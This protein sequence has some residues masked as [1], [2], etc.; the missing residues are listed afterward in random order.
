MPPFRNLHLAALISA[1]MLS[2]GWA[3]SPGGTLRLEI[4]TPK[5][6]ITGSSQ[7]GEV[8]RLDWIASQLE[9]QRADG[10]WLQTADWFAFFS[11]AAGRTA[12]EA[13]GVPAADYRAIRFVV[14][15]DKA[16]N[17]RTPDTFGSDHSLRPAIDTMHWGWMGGFIFLA[18]EGT[19]PQGAFSYHL[20]ND[21]KATT[22]TLPVSFKGGGPVT[23]SIALDVQRLLSGIDFASDPRSSHSREGDPVVEKLRKAMP[24]AFRVIDVSNELFQTLSPLMVSAAPAGTHPVMLR[25]PQRFPQLRLPADNPLTEEGIA[26]GARLFADTRLSI[27]NTQSCASC[28]ERGRAFADA[29]QFS[30][31]AE[32]Q[33]GKRNAMALFN[34]AWHDGFFW[35]GRARTL[36]EQVLMPV[37]DKHEMNETL[38]RVVAKLK[39]D[40]SY[41]AAF[42]SAFGSPEVTPDRLAMALEQHLLSITS[43]DSKFDHAVRKVEALSDAEARGLK[44]FVT[45][46]DPARGLRGADCFHCHGGMLF[47]NHA[48]HNNGLTLAPD[49]IGREAVT[50]NSADRGKFKTPSL[51]NIALTA[52]Y[53]HDGRFKTLE[54]V[55]EHYDH[56]LARSPTLDPN[57]AKHPNEGLR[58]TDEEKADLVAFLKTLTD[59]SLAQP[60]TTLSQNLPSKPSN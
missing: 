34:L 28:H 24:K 10:S 6:P 51:R 8:S 44:L 43:Q 33:V 46:F 4:V 16:T 14:G 22:L 39:D 31:G 21:G 25:V 18:V 42:R 13:T 12:A 53:M 32:G 29:R 26:L 7:G 3:A 47:T 11:V 54:E 23:V 57:L 55:V 56:G 50:K 5:T 19:S 36:R 38:P 15:L 52:P 59:T 45:E 20:A 17:A 2:G 49:D 48:F 41:Q 1:A 9:L 58:L 30:V 27:N 37:Q 35:D 60:A 40:P